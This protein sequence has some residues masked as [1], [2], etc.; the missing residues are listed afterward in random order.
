VLE[1]ARSAFG[2]T[3]QSPAVRERTRGEKEKAPAWTGAFLE[4]ARAFS[5]FAAG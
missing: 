4:N 5:Y 1:H 3:V 2:H